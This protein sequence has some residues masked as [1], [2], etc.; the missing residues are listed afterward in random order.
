[1]SWLKGS[2]DRTGGAEIEEQQAGERIG[3]SGGPAMLAERQSSLSA[4]AAA[5]GCLPLTQTVEKAPLKPSTEEE[6]PSAVLPVVHSPGRPPLVIHGSPAGGTGGG[7]P[8]PRRR[9][10]FQLVTLSLVILMLLITLIDVLPVGPGDSG[11]G[12]NPLRS[13]ISFIR[14]GQDNTYQ[15]GSQAAT[16]TAVT[17]DGYDSGPL[18]YPGLPLQPT[19][20]DL[21]R[22]AYG[23]CTYWANLRYHELTGY[24]VPWQGDAYQWVAGA[25]QYGWVVSSQPHVPSIIVLQP[26][27]QGASAYGHV[28]VVER[29]N[30]DGSV[31]TSNYNWY[32]NG[33]WN[34]LSY[35][36]FYPGPGVA[37]V[38]HP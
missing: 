18:H 3:V 29:I 6:R 9:W 1:M 17:Q 31:Y 37:F 36:T 12:F 27:V 14:N 21:N 8:A 19:E 13:V 2:R 33:G 34:R 35:A 10:W 30:P 28:A 24:W 25:E 26:G 23:Q 38:W 22:F 16:A 11:K 7:P 20:G 15:I 32:A 4:S 5:D